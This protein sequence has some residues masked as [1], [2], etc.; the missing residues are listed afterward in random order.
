VAECFFCNSFSPLLGE[1]NTLYIGLEKRKRK[2]PSLLLIPNTK[3]VFQNTKLRME[4]SEKRLKTSNNMTNICCF[5]N[6]FFALG[7]LDGFIISNV[8]HSVITFRSPERMK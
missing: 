6:F 2:F 4:K 5:M 7:S 1:K 3:R 8:I